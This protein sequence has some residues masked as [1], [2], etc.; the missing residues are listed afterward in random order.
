MRKMAALGAEIVDPA[1]GSFLPLFGPDELEFMLYELK[2]S[3]GRYLGAHPRAPVRSLAELIEANRRRADEVM[4]FF[5]QELFEMANSRG[6]LDS[7]AYLELKETCRRMAREEGIDKVLKA[8]R[9][10]A[11]VA[12]TDGHPAWSIDPVVGDKI[13]GGCSTPPAMARYPHVTVPAGYVHGLPVAVSF[14]GAAFADAQLL[15][16]A[17]A[18]E[19]A[20]LARCP[21]AFP[22]TVPAG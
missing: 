14:Y 10:D 16:Y 15:G 3:I 17:Y 19:Q 21:P 9:L 12:P 18:F 7:P 11:I 22:P 6:G 8:H 20:T 2:A 13:K 1:N 4:P 5:Q